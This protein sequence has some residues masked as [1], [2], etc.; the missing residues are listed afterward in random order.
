M[1]N[2]FEQNN[3]FFDDESHSYFDKTTGKALISPSRIIKKY[4]HPFDPTGEI[5][6]RCATKEGVTPEELRAKWRK[7]GDDSIVRG[8]SIHDSFEQYIKTGV[9]QEDENAD[10]INDFK[11]NV[12][13][14]LD[15][16][17]YPEVTLANIEHGIAGR[18]DLIHV[19]WDKIIDVADFKTN[20]K[21]NKYSFGKF[22]L[23]PLT[24]L[25]DSMFQHYE[26]QLSMYAFML[27]NQGY[28]PR[29]LKLLWINPKRKI[30]V[31]PVQYKR[32]DVVAMLKHYHEEKEKN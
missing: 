4:A 11:K 2:P 32:T 10:I 15:G 18:T 24:H 25:P 14:E 1:P 6:K 17:L 3:I 5:L 19:W 30:Q 21:I 26:I 16:T 9:I 23:P 28:C 31:M 13:V 27:E 20:K 22:M 29:N 7:M 8:H 12:Q